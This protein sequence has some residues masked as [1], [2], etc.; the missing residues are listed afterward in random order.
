MLIKDKKWQDIARFILM[1]IITIFPWFARTVII[2]GYL[3]Y[4]Y[5]SID[6]FS[7]DWKIPKEKVI[8]DA[9]EIKTWGRGIYN[10][11]LV[12]LKISEWFPNWFNTTLPT[13]GKL[14]IILDIMCIV[15]FAILVFFTIKKMIMQ[16]DELLVLG[17][18]IASYIFWQ[19]S[20]PLLRYGYAYI[21]LT[22]LI[23]IGIIWKNAESFT[24]VANTI[25]C[26]M[27]IIMTVIKGMSFAVYVYGNA[28]QPYYVNQ[29]DYG[30]YELESYAVNGVTFYYPTEGDQVGY[31]YFPAIPVKTDIIFR[32]EDISAGFKTDNN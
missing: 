16:Y 17:S 25:A 23:T 18:V 5:P 8:R 28:S 13:V 26:I 27:L 10:A 31:D 32:G 29:K 7:V 24:K 2:S 9:A 19:V 20:A 12:D 6:I 1:G 22:I 15:A 21:I 30:K 4:P 14:F 11:D 3:I